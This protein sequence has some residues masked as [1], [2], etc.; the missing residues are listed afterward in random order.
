M[1]KRIKKTRRKI[2][3]LKCPKILK[4]IFKTKRMKMRTMKMMKRRTMI[5][6]LRM[7]VEE[8]NGIEMSE[9]FESN[10]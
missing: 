1:T 8:D 5:M 10:L 7:K 2:T 6:N 3:E 9:N 4:A